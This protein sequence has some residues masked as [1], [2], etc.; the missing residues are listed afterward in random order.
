MEGCT[1]KGASV[2]RGGDTNGAAAAYS[3]NKF[4]EWLNKYAPPE[5]KQMDF[6]YCRSGSGKGQIAQQ[7]FWYLA[8]TADM[9][10]PGLPVVNADGTPKWRVAPSPHGPYW[11]PG[12]K[13][14]YQ[15][16]VRGLW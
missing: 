12:M 3:V 15:T 10:K 9:T 11:K 16:P 7:I 14:G 2:E 5:A 1:P 8:F 6:R 4:I 13:L